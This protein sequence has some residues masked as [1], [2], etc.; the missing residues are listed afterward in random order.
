M[1]KYLYRK[2]TTRHFGF[3]PSATNAGRLLRS[4]DAGAWTALRPAPLLLSA[5]CPDPCLLSSPPPCLS[6]RP[7]TSTALLPTF[8]QRSSARLFPTLFICRRAA[9]FLSHLLARQLLLRLHLTAH[10]G[11]DWFRY[12]PRA[13]LVPVPRRDSLASS[14][15]LRPIFL[16][17]NVVRATGLVALSGA[18]S[19]SA[20]AQVFRWSHSF[21]YLISTGLPR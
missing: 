4:R 2:S 11:P 20:F 18:P 15:A 12:I 9:S 14:L 13:L 3:H 19:P 21:D 5:L 8:C 6:T 17:S 7:T 16:L 1:S 10:R